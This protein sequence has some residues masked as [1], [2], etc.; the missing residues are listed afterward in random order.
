MKKTI[1]IFLFGFVS[2]ISCG[3]TSDDIS[4]SDNLN[5][6]PSSS[7]TDEDTASLTPFTARVNI[8]T[9]YATTDKIID[10]EWVAVGISRPYALQIDE[11]N[12]YQGKHTFRF[13]LQND[14]NSLQGYN[15]GETK[16]RS[17]LSYCYATKEDFASLPAKA[18]SD[19]QRMKTVYHHGKGFC[20]QG[21]AW[22]Y[23]F[24][25]YVPD[26]IDKDVNTIFA[27]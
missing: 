21:T 11:K 6:Q 7:E 26:T 23:H 20:P 19:A 9:E 10:N 25:V 16:G 2:L 3:Y 17:E 8:Q 14:D 15:E 24:A 27:Q 4:D 18:Y 12:R 5:K 1:S 22:N 13:E